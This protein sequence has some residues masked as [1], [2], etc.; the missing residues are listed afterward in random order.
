MP[1]NADPNETEPFYLKHDL[2]KPIESRPTFFVRFLNDIEHRRLRKLLDEAAAE[3]DA[4][5]ATDMIEE[6]IRIGVVGCKNVVY[7]GQQIEFKQIKRFGEFLSSRELAQLAWGQLK[8]IL[9]GEEDR[10]FSESQ[11]DSGQ[12]ESAPAAKANAKPIAGQAPQS[13][14]APNV[15]E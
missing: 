7:R 9:I 8:T 11:P 2:G 15:K 14:I 5:K 1:I 3:K 10:F 13:S 12:G 4:D 6:A